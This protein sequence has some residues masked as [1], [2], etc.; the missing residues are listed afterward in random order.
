MHDG[1]ALCIDRDDLVDLLADD[2]ELLRSVARA[3]LHTT[4]GAAA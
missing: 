3:V 4:A 2:I 1:R